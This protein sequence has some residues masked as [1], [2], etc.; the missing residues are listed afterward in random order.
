VRWLRHWGRAS[1]SAW[2]TV[3]HLAESLELPGAE[4]L[5]RSCW[6]E[7][8]DGPP[9]CRRSILQMHTVDPAAQALARQVI[10]TNIGYLL[11]V[12]RQPTKSLWEERD[13][14]S[15]FAHAV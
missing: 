7:Q 2:A 10:A 13:G 11:E 9:R 14:F 6:S 15:F 1:G 3:E 12:Y 8:S 5:P 4:G